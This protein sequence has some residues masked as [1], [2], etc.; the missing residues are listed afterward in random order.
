MGR[1]LAHPELLREF[2]NGSGRRTRIAK[3]AFNE[4]N[5]L[6]TELRALRIKGTPTRGK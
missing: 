2:S 5:Y 1:V 3:L 4:M 6:L